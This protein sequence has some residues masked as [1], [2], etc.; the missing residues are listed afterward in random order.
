[1]R[2][3]ADNRNASLS[4]HVHVSYICKVATRG[5]RQGGLDRPSKFGRVIPE[6]R[7]TKA[8][9]AVVDPQQSTRKY[10]LHE[11]HARGPTAQPEA[12]PGPESHLSKFCRSFPALQASL[13]CTIRRWGR[14]VPFRSSVD[15]LR[16]EIVQELGVPVAQRRRKINGVASFCKFLQQVCLTRLLHARAIESDAGIA[17]QPASK[18]GICQR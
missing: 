9:L 10:Q 8:G 3:N 1:M 18:E 12:V 13:T 15:P 11:Q 14:N 4:C 6:K 16:L 7:L 17:H 5:A 2:W